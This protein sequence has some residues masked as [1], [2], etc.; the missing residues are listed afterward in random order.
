MTRRLF[1]VINGECIEITPEARPETHAVHEDSI[2]QGLRHPVTDEIFDSK[3]KYLK[4]TRELGLE[5]VGDDL[6]SRRERKVPDYL[7]EEK[8]MDK[9]EK[10]EAI[11]SDPTRLREHHNRNLARFEEQQRLLRYGR[12]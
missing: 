11:V 12:N 8:I 4:R 3:A 5:V 7:T 10:A 6:L 9:F 2:P 1:R